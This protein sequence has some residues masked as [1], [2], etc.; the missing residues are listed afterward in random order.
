MHSGAGLSGRRGSGLLTPRSQEMVSSAPWPLAFHTPDAIAHTPDRMI[1][2]GVRGVAC[3]G[4]DDAQ[5]FPA[6][7]RELGGWVAWQ[8][9]AIAAV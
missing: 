8:G 5:L 3:L 4:R 7:A 2:V 1:K 6:V 9:H